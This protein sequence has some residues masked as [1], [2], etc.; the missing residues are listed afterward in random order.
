MTP[1]RA[2]KYIKSVITSG[3]WAPLMALDRIL[4]IIEEVPSPPDIV[5][6]VE[7]RG[8]KFSFLVEDSWWTYDNKKHPQIVVFVDGNLERDLGPYLPPGYGFTCETSI[9]CPALSL[10]CI[11]L[12]A[13]C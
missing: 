2:L 7:F 8:S 13:F 9:E 6:P 1:E 12:S 3:E 5:L 11:I 10:S 4:E